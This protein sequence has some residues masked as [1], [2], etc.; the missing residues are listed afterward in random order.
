MGDNLNVNVYM[1]NYIYCISKPRTA[2][3]ST[4]AYNTTVRA[5]HLNR[6]E[7]NMPYEGAV[8]TKLGSGRPYVR[9]YVHTYV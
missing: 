7:E 4:C 5:S 2:F 3:D 8:H 9:T 1:C 6:N